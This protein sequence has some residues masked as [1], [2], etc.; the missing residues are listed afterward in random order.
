MV[1]VEEKQLMD[2]EKVQ[3]KI[4]RLKLPEA[5]FIDNQIRC[6]LQSYGKR[7]NMSAGLER[8][9][10]IL[11]KLSYRPVYYIWFNTEMGIRG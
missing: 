2:A 4:E 1:G 9:R 5:E 8:T 7:R 11:S 3:R 6:F 10:Y